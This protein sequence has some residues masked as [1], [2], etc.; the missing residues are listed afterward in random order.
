MS[1]SDGVAELN[2]ITTPVPDIACQQSGPPDGPRVLERAGHNPP[3]E[4]P[5]AFAPAVLEL[6]KE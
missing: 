2:R 4:A 5:K 6:C 3:Q 1:G